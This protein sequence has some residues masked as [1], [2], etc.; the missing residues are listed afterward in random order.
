MI[1]ILG[2]YNNYPLSQ[3]IRFATKEPVSHFAICFDQ[4]LI[5]HT[6]PMGSHPMWR[7]TFDKKNT[8]Y[9]EYLLPSTPLQEEQIYLNIVN[10]FDSKPYDVM[11]LAYLFMV[12]YPKLTL[13]G[14]LP[15]SNPWNEKDMYICTEIAYCLEPI[16]PDIKYLDISVLTPMQVI[17]AILKGMKLNG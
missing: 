10:R 8:T 5:F 3:A 9:C 1:S 13:T 4:R 6:N 14:Q 11:A 15:K 12:A 7:A 17:N 16:Y 2:T